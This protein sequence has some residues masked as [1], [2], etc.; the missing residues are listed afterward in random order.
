MLPAAARVER[1]RNPGHGDYASN[2]ALQVARKAGLPPREL[3]QE[4]ADQL[5]SDPASRTSM[6]RAPASSTS[7]WMPRPLV[8]SRRSSSRQGDEYGRGD[9]SG[10]HMNLEFVSANPTGPLHIGGVRWAAVGDALARIFDS[11]AASSRTSTTSTTTG[12]RSTGSPR[13]PSPG[14]ANQHRRTATQ[15]TTSTRSPARVAKHPD[16]LEHP[17]AQSPEIFRAAAS[18]SCSTIS[19]TPF[20]T[21]ACIS[22]CSSTRTTCTTGAVEHGPAGSGTSGRLRGRR[23]DLV[24]DDRLRRRQGPRLHPSDG[25]YSYMSADSPTT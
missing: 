4:I 24:P 23:R 6:S 11:R 10:H 13:S 16:P 22:M 17:D 19:R 2:L 1:P 25:E 20:S 5:A 3:A 8:R 15:A 21:S 14:R 7:G 18:S 12:A 9:L